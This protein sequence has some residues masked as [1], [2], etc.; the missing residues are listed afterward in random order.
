MTR[1]VIALAG[2]TPLCAR[3][4]NETLTLADVTGT[5]EGPFQFQVSTR[6]VER[7][8]RWVLQQKGG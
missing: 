4:S 2:S 5:W 6:G 1:A 7:T 8:I 3:L